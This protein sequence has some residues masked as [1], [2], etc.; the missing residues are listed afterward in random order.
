M[1]RE[2][3]LF[4]L[5]VSIKATKKLR[6]EFYAGTQKILENPYGYPYLDER[7]THRKYIF[8]KR[9]L[10]IYLVEK[11]IIYIE[12]IVDTRQNYFKNNFK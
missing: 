9:Y 3:E 2:H 10:I 4:L 11:T 8:Y 5:K 6:E 7:K 12:Y 1:L